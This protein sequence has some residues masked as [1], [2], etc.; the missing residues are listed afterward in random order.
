MKTSLIALS[1]LAAV[2]AVGCSRQPS[3]PN[4][5]PEGKVAATTAP[6]T[7]A[8]PPVSGT[9]APA[10]GADALLTTPATP[11]V[12]A[13]GLETDG[14]QLAVSAYIWGYPLVRMERVARDY[15]NVPSPKPDTSYRAPLNQI[16][17][18]TSLATPDAHDM[19]TANNDTFY[20]SAVV[21]LDEP[22]ILSVPDTNDRYYVV[23][24]FDMYQELEHYIGRRTTGT[25]A[26]RYAIVPPGWKGA[27]PP[28]AKRL[29]VSTNKVWLWGRLRIAQGEPVEPVLALQ[30]QFELVPL[31]AFG[32]A[33][34]ASKSAEPL[35]PLPSVQ[36]D[37]FGFFT[38]LG[39][40]VQNNPIRETDKAL[41]GQFARI[42]LTEKGFDP[43]TLNPQVRAGMARGLADAPAVAVAALAS[44]A[45]KRNGWDWVT[46]LDSFG[47]NYS[48]RAVVAGP[49]LGGNGEHEAM[50]P[51]RYTD[52]KG[53]VLNGKH[54][55]SIHFDSAPPVDAFWS[56]TMYN[57]GD[58]MLVANEINRYKVG[59]DTQ[60]L[61]KAADGSFTIPIQ[62][63]K[64]AGDDAAN[65]LPAPEGDFYVILRMYQPSDAVLSDQW[66]MPQLNRVD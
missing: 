48:L 15:T 41:F 29:D 24:V 8:E 47:Y 35:K 53:E 19:P 65:W 2:V 46:G 52:A 27:L 63:D 20:M 40:A 32:K 33:G 13:K 61:K 25:K 62:H 22:Y 44:T 43:S 21:K 16:G 1:I 10:D 6:T 3:E 38:E 60:G 4:G 56:V 51:I 57:A 49:Y 36:G 45:T 9:K 12:V 18:A 64:P 66:K 28:G 7:T 30:K 55:Y 50:Y 23:N 54:R 42:G 26:A 34:A 17:W 59:T 58:K 39:A 11:E 37:E 5:A 14:Y 31:S